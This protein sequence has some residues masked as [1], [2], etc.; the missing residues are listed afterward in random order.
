MW[1]W[2]VGEHHCLTTHAHRPLLGVDHTPSDEGPEPER[3]STPETPKMSN[4]KMGLVLTMKAGQEAGSGDEQ[5][6]PTAD[7]Q[8]MVLWE[9]K[10][11]PGG[12]DANG[13]GN[14][15]DKEEKGADS[16]V[17]LEQVNI[18]LKPEEPNRSPSPVV[19][20]KV[21]DDDTLTRRKG[22]PEGEA[23]VDPKKE[24][25]E[26]DVEAVKEA[27]GEAAKQGTVPSEQAVTPQAPSAA[28]EL[29]SEPKPTP[30]ARKVSP[31]S[32]KPSSADAKKPPPRASGGVAGGRPARPK[33]MADAKEM[34]PVRPA[35]P[36]KP[37]ISGKRASQLKMSSLSPESS[38]ES[39]PVR[40]TGQTR[41]MSPKSSG[42]VAA[43][44][45]AVAGRGV[46]AKP[47]S[48][49]VPGKSPARQPVAT[50]SPRGRAA[51][52]TGNVARPDVSP[53]RVSAAKPKSDGSPSRGQA[54]K[55]KTSTSPSHSPTMK[56]KT[57][58]PPSRAA[59]S[60][61]SQGGGLAVERPITRARSDET[62]NS[63]QSKEKEGTDGGGEAKQDTSATK[64]DKGDEE[65]A[66]KKS[67]AAPKSSVEGQ[68]RRRRRISSASTGR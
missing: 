59:A 47:K 9:S 30:A 13:L 15:T 18:S 25:E 45:D 28:K 51:A 33:S 35:V 20:Q 14:L 41:E 56:R 22:K 1:V 55:P 40:Q 42:G 27:E 11:L 24:D 2:C 5:L 48:T 7:E 34:S 64:T 31:A 23:A 49:A 3:F 46:T 50:A 62:N 57:D 16:T 37:A 67:E 39:S 61:L 44:K 66:K 10:D 19:T 38:K 43:K 21:M 12:L 54:S 65:V 29:A 32:S 4:P 8:P 53:S 26:R 17:E 6:T 58:L 52:K 60:K 68:K 36:A 63:S